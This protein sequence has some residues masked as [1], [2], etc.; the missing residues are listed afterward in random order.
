MLRTCNNKGHF[1]LEK[2][3]FV[4]FLKLTLNGMGWKRDSNPYNG[5]KRE[6]SSIRDL[7]SHLKVNL[8]SLYFL[9]FSCQCRRRLS[10]V[11][12]RLMSFF[13]GLE[14]NQQTS[15]TELFFAVKPSFMAQAA[16]SKYSKQDLI[17]T[18]QS[19]LLFYLPL[20]TTGQLLDDKYLWGLCMFITSV[21]SF[22]C[23]KVM[24][25]NQILAATGDNQ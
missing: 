25:E 15:W 7:F 21:F 9:F 5:P 16:L 12:I 3:A 11:Y 4:W 2:C 17:W 6:N 1:S 22:I 20:W 13:V 14:Y 10:T 18:P 8:F 23:I 24:K 19:L